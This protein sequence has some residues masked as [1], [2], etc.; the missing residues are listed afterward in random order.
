[1]HHSTD[2]TVL[3]H[4]YV[5]RGK[6]AEFESL[7]REHRAGLEESGLINRAV[8]TQIYRITEEA[9]TSLYIEIFDWAS[10]DAPG[11]AHTHPIIGPLWSRISDLCEARGADGAQF[12]F[13]HAK[14]LQ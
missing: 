8:A 2:T 3:A 7:L 13:P 6:E 11:V 4:Y 12:H 1:M 10:P 14:R 9:G 5:Q